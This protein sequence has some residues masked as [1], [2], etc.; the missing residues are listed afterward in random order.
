MSREASQG[1]FVC[2]NSFWGLGTRTP[3][4][5]TSS[6]RHTTTDERTN[7]RTTREISRGHVDSS[8]ETLISL[9]VA[10]TSSGRVAKKTGGDGCARDGARRGGRVRRRRSR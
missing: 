6:A 10:K 1:V 7:G 5:M 4:A 2:V 9:R 3:N 8:G